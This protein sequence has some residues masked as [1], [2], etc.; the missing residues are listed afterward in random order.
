MGARTIPPRCRGRYR[1]SHRVAQAGSRGSARLHEETYYG[2]IKDERKSD[3]E[4]ENGYNVVT[5]GNFGGHFA[6]FAPDKVARKIELI[7]D[8][9]IRKELEAEL[10]QATNA[11]DVTRIVDAYAKRKGIRRIRL[12]KKE[13]TVLPIKHTS[14]SGQVFEKGVVPGADSDL[15]RP[16]NPRFIRS[17]FRY[18]SGHHSDFYP[19]TVPM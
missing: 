1:Q 15:S 11:D 6:E 8:P 7:R 14:I 3:Y 12:L 4:R 2:I 16:P 5:R 13:A 19:A 17:P 18:L 9:V 10:S